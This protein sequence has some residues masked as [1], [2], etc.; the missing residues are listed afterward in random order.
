MGGRRQKTLGALNS[1]RIGEK[2]EL[3]KFLNFCLERSGKFWKELKNYKNE[4]KSSLGGRRQKPIGV[5]NLP[6]ISFQQILKKF[7]IK[8]KTKHDKN[9]TK[10]DKT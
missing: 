9:E 8:N 1:P 3:Q 10:L 4:Y 2:V 5:L 6:R 7:K